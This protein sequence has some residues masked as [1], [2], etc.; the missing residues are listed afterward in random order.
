MG[1]L[2]EGE[3]QREEG[4]SRER[5]TSKER[6]E[7]WRIF[8]EELVKPLGENTAV[9]SGMLVG[10]RFHRISPVLGAKSIP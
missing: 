4:I 7:E 6:I 3:W 5:G 1:R 10:S 8:V 9:I 2:Y